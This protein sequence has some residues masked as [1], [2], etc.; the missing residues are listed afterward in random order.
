MIL[1]LREKHVPPD[2]EIRRRW[3]KLYVDEV[4][5]V[6]RVSKQCSEFDNSDV[7]SGRLY[8]SMAELITA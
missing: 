8:K 4:M 1:F 3:S 2:K 6:Q 7:G 5:T